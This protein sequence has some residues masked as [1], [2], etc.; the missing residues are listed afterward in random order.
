MSELTLNDLIIDNTLQCPYDPQDTYN[1]IHHVEIFTVDE[2]ED[3]TGDQVRLFIESENGPDWQ[4][5]FTFHEGQTTV[6]AEEYG[7]RREAITSSVNSG[8]P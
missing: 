3:R 7:R 1:R 2:G 5:T 8:C 6:L 4:L